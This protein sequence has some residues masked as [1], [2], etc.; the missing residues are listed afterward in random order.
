MTR[1][2]GGEETSTTSFARVVA[3]SEYRRSSSDT[4][5]AQG[6]ELAESIR[7]HPSSRERSHQPKRQ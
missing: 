5:N 1:P 6:G 3:M 4:T 2:E 7:R